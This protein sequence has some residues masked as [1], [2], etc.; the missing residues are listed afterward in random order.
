MNYK[1]SHKINNMQ[2][3]KII[4]TIF[5]EFY[6]IKSK[7]KNTF[8]KAFHPIFDYL[9]N[10]CPNSLLKMNNN[11]KL[12]NEL[13]KHIKNLC[14]NE[15][16][17]LIDNN[18]SSNPKI[19]IRQITKEL[20]LNVDKIDFGIINYP[21]FTNNNNSK[22]SIETI[23]ILDEQLEIILN[24]AIEHKDEIT[25]F[26]IINHKNKKYN[27]NPNFNN[28]DNLITFISTDKTISLK[29]G[30]SEDIIPTI[31]DYLDILKPKEMKGNSLILKKE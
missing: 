19:Y 17:M 9:F 11:V 15:N 7:E 6:E 13:I 2:N 4:L 1:Y 27:K 8:I 23:E 18:F 25:W 22:E 5:D 3:K 14:P 30:K 16:I 12:T 24:Y 21:I 10:M 29:D 28:L 20:M 26:I 31:L